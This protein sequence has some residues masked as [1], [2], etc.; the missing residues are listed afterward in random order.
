[1]IIIFKFLNLF[2]RTH[3]ALDHLTGSLSIKEMMSQPGIKLPSNLLGLG[4]FPLSSGSLGSS[5]TN[6]FIC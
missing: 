5:Q 1:M 2:Y 4:T 6:L 3:E